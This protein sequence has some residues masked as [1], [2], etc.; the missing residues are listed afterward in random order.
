M[1][2]IEELLRK[3]PFLE[4]GKSDKCITLE[5]INELEQVYEIEGSISDD[6][7][8]L[9]IDLSRV[10][11][12]FSDDII[13]ANT[14]FIYDIACDIKILSNS[15]EGDPF[16]WI[17]TID[18]G[19]F[20]YIWIINELNSNALSYIRYLPLFGTSIDTEYV[21]IDLLSESN[22]N[23]VVLVDLISKITDDESE[24]LSVLA[25]TQR[26]FINNLYIRD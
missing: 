25:E 23:R 3:N 8:E 10:K 22:P 7:K 11:E 21:C 17:K 19:S 2:I 1:K 6:M 15:R 9:I 4:L 16:V 5:D 13:V 26:E 12:K 14:P 24:Y 18:Y 20:N